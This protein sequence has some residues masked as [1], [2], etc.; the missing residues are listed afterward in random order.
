MTRTIELP[1]EAAS[2]AFAASLAMML[3]PGDLILLE[4]DL[5]TGKTTIARALIRA[6]ANDPELEVPSPTFTLVQ[7]Y[8]LPGFAISHPRSLPRNGFV[9]V[10]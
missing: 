7:P 2:T 10:P 9:M 8:D 3:R 4:G 6:V 5:G 1:G